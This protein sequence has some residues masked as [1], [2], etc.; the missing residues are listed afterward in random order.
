MGWLVALLFGGMVGLDATSFPQ[1]MSSRPLVAGAITGLLMGRPTEGVLLGVI[2]ELFA[3]PVLPFGA[4]G[5]PEGGT[6]AVGSV[7]AYDWV[8]PPFAPEILFLA[9]AFGLIASHVTGWSVRL[10][11]TRNGRAVGGSGQLAALDPDEVERTHV[12]AMVLDF[13]RGSVVTVATAIVL[14]LLL[15]A[16]QAVEW[17]LPIDPLDVLIVATAAMIGASLT[18]FGTVRERIASFT[19]G[20][21]VTTLVVWLV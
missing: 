9:V 21:A 13:A 17:A 10:L 16:A 1:A 4:A 5:Y 12:R 8:A 14:A 11:R 6:A 15:R 2:L 18:I 19:I 20:A 3:L 7:I